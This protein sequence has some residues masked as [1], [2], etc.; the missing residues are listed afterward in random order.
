MSRASLT[1]IGADGVE[2]DTEGEAN[3]VLASHDKSTIRE[4][5]AVDEL[6]EEL[7]QRRREEMEPAT[8]EQLRK[9]LRRGMVIVKEYPDGRIEK[10]YGDG[11]PVTAPL[12]DQYGCLRKAKR[13]GKPLDG[14]KPLWGQCSVCDGYLCPAHFNEL[15]EPDGFI[16]CLSCHETSL[17]SE[18]YRAKIAA[19]HERKRR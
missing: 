4:R 16:V 2:Y 9:A 14:D 19:A 11:T 5:T 7:K 12:C 17:H 6:A 15:R 8:R 18:A 3:A 13:V 10:T 1:F